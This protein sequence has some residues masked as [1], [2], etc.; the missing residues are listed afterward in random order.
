MSNPILQVL[1]FPPYPNIGADWGAYPAE[2]RDKINEEYKIALGL[3]RKNNELIYETNKIIAEKIKLETAGI[4]DRKSFEETQLYKGMQFEL[5]DLKLSKMAL[6]IE[7]R[8]QF[9]EI[10]RLGDLYYKET[11]EWPSKS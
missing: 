7:N 6:E 3:V 1:N 10:G 8:E 5:N 4:I 9:Q 11:G 2:L